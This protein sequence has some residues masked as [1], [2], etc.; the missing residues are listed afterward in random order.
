MS[1]NYSI[2]MVHR[3]NIILS[4]QYYSI[5]RAIIQVCKSGVVKLYI[6]IR[7]YI[8]SFVNTNQSFLINMLNQS[9]SKSCLQTT[10]FKLCFVE[11]SK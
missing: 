6:T 3:Q 10:E 2:T 8:V 9:N 5:N 7:I 4:Y 1:K 11:Q